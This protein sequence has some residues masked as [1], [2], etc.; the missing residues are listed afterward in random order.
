[1]RSLSLQNMALIR[2]AYEKNDTQV[3]PRMLPPHLRAQP[4]LR[5]PGASA[6]KLIDAAFVHEKSFACP[7][8]E[9][10]V[11]NISFT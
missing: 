4:H 11:P 10:A 7:L 5:L 9:G 1:M 6:C 3:C 8:G 2:T